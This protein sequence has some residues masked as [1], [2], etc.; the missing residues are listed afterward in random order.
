MTITVLTPNG[1]DFQ[2]SG[3]LGQM[4]AGTIQPGGSSTSFT[5]VDAADDL[6]FVLDGNDFTYGSGDGGITVPAAR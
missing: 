6:E 4:G 5:I 3:P 1:L 2:A